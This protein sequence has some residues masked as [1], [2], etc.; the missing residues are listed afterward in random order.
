M[1]KHVFS[2]LTSMLLSFYEYSLCTIVI[3]LSPV[4]YG[5]IDDY[6]IRTIML[7]ATVLLVFLCTG[8]FDD[9]QDIWVKLFRP[10]SKHEILNGSKGYIP[11]FPF[12]SLSLSFFLSVIFFFLSLLP[13][14]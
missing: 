11:L 9:Y 5:M 4:I 7:L 8:A 1:K 2:K 14:M 6:L 3:A 10:F 12:L 13:L